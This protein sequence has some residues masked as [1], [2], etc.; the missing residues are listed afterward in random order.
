MRRAAP[1]CCLA[2]LAH[3]AEILLPYGAS[4]AHLLLECDLRG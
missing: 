3:Q 2:P 1:H 4:C